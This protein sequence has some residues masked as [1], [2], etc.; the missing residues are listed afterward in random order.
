FVSF[1][2]LSR[3]PLS[4]QW[5]IPG[6]GAAFFLDGE[7]NRTDTLYTPFIVNPGDTLTT[8][9]SAHVLFTQPGLQTVTLRNVFADS[10]AYIGPDTVSAE[11]Q[12]NGTFLY[13]EDFVVDVYDSIRAN[14]RLI[15]PDDSEL[16]FSTDTFFVEAGT[17][18]RLEDQSTGRPNEWTWLM[19]PIDG[20]GSEISI[21]GADAMNTTLAISGEVEAYRLRLTARRTGE[22]IPGGSNTFTMPNP[23]KITPSAP[24]LTGSISELENQTIQIPFSVPIA[25]FSGKES[26]FSVTLN[27][28]STTVVSASVNSSNNTR[29]DITLGETIYSDDV[30]TM[31]LGAGSGIVSVDG[32][33][34]VTFTDQPVTMF[35]L[36]LIQEAGID[37]LFVDGLRGFEVDNLRPQSGTLAEKV[38]NSSVEF[39]ADGGTD[40]GGVMKINLDN[41]GATADSVS[42][43]LRTETANPLTFESGKQYAINFDYRTE[44]LV[45]QFTFRM[46]TAGIFSNS[47]SLFTKA[48]ATSWTNVNKVLSGPSTQDD[49]GTVVVIYVIGNSGA[50]GTLFLD[51]LQIFESDSRP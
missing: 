40:G 48:T 46:F 44:G 30:I 38:G 17:N 25:A 39:V 31:T 10:V 33:D 9:A 22:N 12:A 19:E 27:G 24:K 37:G 28:A 23:L 26:S 43:Q 14:F 32:L 45:D 34:V 41:T 21:S 49:D 5:S 11:R 47:Q 15:L 42:F 6:E 3:N 4:H 18:L 51:N 29:I 36:D 35:L 16:T 1:T 7:I 8:A 13:E 2:D 20:T 50:D